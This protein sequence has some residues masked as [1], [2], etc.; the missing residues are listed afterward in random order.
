MKKK[1]QA[2]SSDE[3]ELETL[4]LFSSS[5][6]SHTRC[7]RDQTTCSSLLAE[8]KSKSGTQTANEKTDVKT[9]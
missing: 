7:G 5:I 1:S 2:K 8:K 3:A 4:A 9:D 6:D